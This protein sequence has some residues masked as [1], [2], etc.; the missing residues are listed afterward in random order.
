[1]HDAAAAARFDDLMEVIVAL[2]RLRV[3]AGIP[4]R[5][6]PQAALAGTSLDDE[7][8]ALIERLAHVRL[9]ARSLSQPAGFAQPAATALTERVANIDV[10]LLIGAEGTEREIA[11]QEAEERRLIAEVQRLEQKLANASF[12]LKAPPEIVQKEREKLA[13]YAGELQ[14]TRNRLTELQGI[15]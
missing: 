9:R 11:R 6:T 7:E 15:S 13:G 10:A 5:E 3:D 4:A 2:R 14:R 8:T 12:A 1:P